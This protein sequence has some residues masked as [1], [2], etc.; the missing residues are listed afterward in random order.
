MADEAELCARCGRSSSVDSDDFVDWDLLAGDVVCPDCL[1]LEEWEA[2]KEGAHE[3]ARDAVC[4]RCG[5][6]PSSDY[7]TLEDLAE[8]RMGKGGFGICAACLTYEERVQL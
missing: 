5:R 8:W 7:V 4:S 1:S 2:I 3:L 6:D